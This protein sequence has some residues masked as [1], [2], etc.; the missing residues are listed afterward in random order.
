MLNN[1]RGFTLLEMLVVLV[2]VGFI[3]TLLL[4]G[5]A[6]VLHLRSR[7][8]IQLGDV[9]Q[10]TLQEHWFRSTTA[11]IVTDYKQGEFIFQGK[12]HQFSGLTLSALDAT[13]GV[14]TPF[15]WQLDYSEG[16]MVLR[17]QNSQGE[18]WEVA[19]WFGDEGYFRYMTKD[20]KW[21]NQ[22]P[23]QFGNNTAQIPR[24]ILLYGKRRQTPI[25]WIV[26]LAEH[27]ATRIDYRL[28]DW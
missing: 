4:Q 13:L 3:T 5:F 12:A 25:T 26:K 19:D 7:F 10:A 21:H 17:Y 14:P 27:D 9:Q 6:Y 18:K 8:L 2:L 15:T 11:A 28:E 23:P 1:K 16:M 22:W 20:G 24:L